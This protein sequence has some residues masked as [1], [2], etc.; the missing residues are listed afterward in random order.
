MQ[1]RKGK[2]KYDKQFKEEAVRLVI[3][4][5]RKVTEVARSLGIH[6]NV[7]IQ[8]RVVISPL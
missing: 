3:E 8:L 6:E 1:E 4:G 7:T 5:G 2:R